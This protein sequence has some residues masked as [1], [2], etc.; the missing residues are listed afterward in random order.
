MDCFKEYASRIEGAVGK[1]RAENLIKNA[2]FVISAGTNDYVLNYYGPPI[3][4]HTYTISAY[5]QFLVQIIQQF[6]QV[7]SLLPTLEIHIILTQ[8]IYSEKML[9]CYMLID[10]ISI[11][12]PVFT[13]ITVKSFIECHPIND[14]S[15]YNNFDNLVPLTLF[16]N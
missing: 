4:R 8:L 9:Q 3:R 13:H 1:E 15:F 7:R 5:H 6:I 2:V 12:P 14:T 11:D 10:Y 16:I